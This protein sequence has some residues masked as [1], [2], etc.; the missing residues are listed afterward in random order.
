MGDVK[1]INWLMEVTEIGEAAL[2][3]NIEVV[4]D[5][6]YSKVWKIHIKSAFIF[7]K[8][9]PEKLFL[10]SGVLKILHESCNILNTPNLIAENKK[11]SCFLMADCGGID[12]RSYFDG[13]FELDVFAQALS[14]YKTLQKATVPYVD[15]FIH[16]GIPDWRLDK[17][18][19]LYQEIIENQ[20][21]LNALGLDKKEQR[22]LHN[23]SVD[24]SYACKELASY[25]IPECFNNCDFKDKNILYRKERLDLSFIDFGQSAVCHPFFSLTYSL[26][27]SSAYYLLEKK[28]K[29]Y[30]DLVYCYFGSW[31]ESDRDLKEVLRLVDK[32][33]PIYALLVL[34]HLIRSGRSFLLNKPLKKYR[35]YLFY[36]RFFIKVNSLIDRK[37]YYDYFS[38]EGY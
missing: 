35:V 5:I 38:S 30:K 27:E 6:S 20:K 33:Y 21:L 14:S 29:I 32:I 37:S 36:L 16:L 1:V 13:C 2:R 18:P 25:P 8:K 28:S 15:K 4:V 31:L 3:D 10:E 12:L 9:I 34:M 22:Q 7:L 26:G 17:L 24:F 11:L 23:L 19:Y